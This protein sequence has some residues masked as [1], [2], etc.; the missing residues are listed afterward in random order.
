M[1]LYM[2]NYGCFFLVTPSN[3][4]YFYD[5]G[6][7]HETFYTS[8]QYVRYTLQLN[9]KGI[10]ISHFHHDHSG[11]S[12][13][14]S[15]FNRETMEGVYHAGWYS[16]GETHWARPS[17]IP[18]QEE[19][20]YVLDKYNIPEYYIGQDTGLDIDEGEDIS[21]EVINPNKAG[22][23]EETGSVGGLSDD[24][25]IKVN[26]GDCSL[27]LTGDMPTGTAEDMLENNE[28]D[29]TCDMFTLLHHDNYSEKLIDLLQPNLAIADSVG[30]AGVS[31]LQGLGLEVASWRTGRNAEYEGNMYIEMKKDGSYTV[32]TGL[33][34]PRKSTR[35]WKHNTTEFKS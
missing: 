30:S 29:V 10:F 23:G 7:D 32:E 27:M 3:N 16:D 25:W 5:T 28:K 26:Y 18:P 19:L 22:T 15:R 1:K 33:E 9:V 34:Q 6:Y 8:L 21:F 24:F 20:L 14:I 17:D 4:V 12:H 2:M 13:R 31:D 35:W 11:G